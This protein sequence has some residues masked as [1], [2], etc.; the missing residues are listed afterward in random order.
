[1]RKTV[2]IFGL[3][4][5]ALYT[6]MMLA[7]FPLIDTIGIEKTD[8][9]GYTT[10]VLSALL[11]FFGIRSFR[12]NVGDGRMTFGRGLAVGLLITLVSSVCYVA[13]FQ[14]AYFKLMPGLGEKY[15]AC[16]IDRARASGASQ[17]EIDEKTKQAQ[18][19]KRLWDNPLTNAAVA[20]AE[21]FPIGLVA[22]A[23]SATI[24]RKR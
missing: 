2:L 5:A 3:I 24:L 19:L 13:A 20:F 8:F 14:I 7:T 11:V 16:M 1:M 4:S 10:F 17:Q 21:P 18:T 9:I 15:A 22:A 6:A 23:I 12:E